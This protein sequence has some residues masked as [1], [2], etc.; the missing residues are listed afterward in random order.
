[1]EFINFDSDVILNQIW[2]NLNTFLFFP[3]FQYFH[4]IR[5]FKQRA[6]VKNLMVVIN[7]L[8]LRFFLK[9]WYSVAIEVNVFP[10]HSEDVVVHGVW[11]F[12]IYNWNKP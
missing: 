9:S 12:L 10:K 11:K 5:Q 6:S 8:V 7:S 3:F 4:H 2:N 1:M